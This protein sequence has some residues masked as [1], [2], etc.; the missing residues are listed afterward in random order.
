MT[1]LRTTLAVSVGIAGLLMVSQP[2]AA[3]Q[4]N[5]KVVDRIKVP[6]GAF[7]YATYDPRTGNIYMARQDVTTVIDPKSG[8]L[9]ELKTAVRGHIALPIPGTSYV[10]LSQ[11][12]GTIRIV[13][14]DKDSVV[15]DLLADKN[16]DGATYDPFTKLVFVMNH[17]SGVSTVGDPAT[18]KPVATIQVGGELEF[19]VSDGAGHVFVND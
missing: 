6:D 2:Q 18:K 3:Q 14:V 11:R 12:Q 15:A 13:D 1:I 4:T 7:D 10:L 19:P 8:K 17:D 9:S 5:Y 16:P